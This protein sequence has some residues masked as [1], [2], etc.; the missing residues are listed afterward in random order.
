MRADQT[1]QGTGA[2]DALVD[3][4]RR[5]EGQLQRAQAQLLAMDGVALPG[6]HL[7]VEASGA[8]ATRRTTSRPCSASRASRRSTRRS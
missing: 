2:R 7:L 4:L 6:L 1:T 8:V 5:L 3:E